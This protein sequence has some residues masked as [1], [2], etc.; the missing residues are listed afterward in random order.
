M[1]KDRVAAHKKGAL[2]ARRSVVLIDETGFMLQP[3]VRATWAP[4]G[5]TPVLKSWDRRDRLTALSA[6]TVSAR[7]RRL[8][9]YFTVQGS[10]AKSDD[11]VAFL[12]WVRRQL[13]RGLIVVLDRLAAH[14]AA[15][16][17]LSQTHGDV[18]RFEWLP[19]YAPELNPVECVWSQSKYG[20]LS[21]LVPRDI[22]DLEDHARDSLD[23]IR[24]EQPRLRGCFAH[25]GL[26]L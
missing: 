12:L 8:G 5:R 17:R 7:R 11:V 4:R 26:R 20:H 2:R 3:L 1:A 6:L 18:F 13:R 16:R 25:A 23:T 19:A 9:L 15:A 22:E 10:N 21:N 14:R 24:H